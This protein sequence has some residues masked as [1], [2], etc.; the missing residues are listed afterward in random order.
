MRHTQRQPD[1]HSASSESAFPPPRDGDNAIIEGGRDEQVAATS[2][3]RLL[4]LREAA[5]LIP[6]RGRRRVHASTIARWITRGV[7]APDGRRVRL[8]AV[9][10]GSKWLTTRAWLEEFAAAQ[11][12][13]FTDTDEPVLTDR[14]RDRAAIQAGRRLANMGA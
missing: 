11:T 4:T 2:A 6:G 3:Q 9:R 13:E 12:P 5:A 14:Q 1:A 10:L 7:R 8:R